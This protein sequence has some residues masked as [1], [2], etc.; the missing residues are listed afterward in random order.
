MRT[1]R[2]WQGLALVIGVLLSGAPWGFCAAQRSGTAS[3]YNVE[4]AIREGTC[5]DA[6]HRRC[7]QA[8]GRPLQDEA[9]TAASWDYP[10]STALQ[11]TGPDG[12]HVR[13]V[14][15]DRGP[16]RTLY[17]HG[18]ILDLSRACFQALAPLAQGIVQV[19]VEAIPE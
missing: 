19:T 2:A 11:I 15:R 7:L 13:C 17:R 14:V 8:N 4:S 6:K 18:R 5:T 16:A 12:S 1:P 9:F 10:F 3:W